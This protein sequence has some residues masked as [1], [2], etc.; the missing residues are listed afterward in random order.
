MTSPGEQVRAIFFSVL[1][2]TSMIAGATA[3]AGATDENPSSDTNLT[4]TGLN[5]TGSTEG[6][7][8]SEADSSNQDKHAETKKENSNETSQ[9]EETEPDDEVR[10]SANDTPE[11]TPE[12]TTEDTPA[13]SNT[14]TN[15]NTSTADFS[16]TSKKDDADVDPPASDKVTDNLEQR[17]KVILQG[18]TTVKAES[19]SIDDSTEE[20]STVTVQRGTIPNNKLVQVLIRASSEDAMESVVTDVQSHGSVV[21]S[22]TDQRIIAAEVPANRVEQII[23]SSA[24]ERVGIDERVSRNSATPPTGT[25]TRQVGNAGSSDSD[26]DSWGMEYIDADLVH[27]SGINGSGVS[28]AVLDGGIDQTAGLQ[29]KVVAEEDLA[30]NSPLD[31]DDPTDYSG[32]GSNVAGI[33]AASEST[34]K[35]PRSSNNTRQIKGVSPGVNLM[36]GKIGT[37]DDTLENRPVSTQSTDITDRQQVDIPVNIPNTIDGLGAGR[38]LRV[39]ATWSDPDDDISVEL[40]DGNGNTISQI[41]DGNGLNHSVQT[42]VD[43]E[44]KTRLEANGTSDFLLTSAP[45]NPDFDVAEIRVIGEN[46]SGTATV[47]LDI[48]KYA[49]GRSSQSTIAEGIY[50]ASGTGTAN[51]FVSPPPSPQQTADVISLSYSVGSSPI[52]PVTG[53]M[54]SAVDNDVV[55]VTSAGNDGPSTVANAKQKTNIISVGA[56]NRSGARAGFSQTG[57]SSSDIYKPDVIAP[58]TDIP[59]SGPT[60][61]IPQVSGQYNGTE[62]SGTSQAAPH[63][64]GVAALYIQMYERVHGESPTPQQVRSGIIAGTSDPTTPGNPLDREYSEEKG[65]GV[66]N[67]YNTYLTFSFNGTNSGE[68]DEVSV[69]VPEELPEDRITVPN[70][71][72]NI[73]GTFYRQDQDD[74]FDV[75]VDGTSAAEYGPIAVAES[76]ITASDVASFTIEGTNFGVADNDEEWALATH[77]PPI[78]QRIENER[79]EGYGF[80]PISLDPGES[81]AYVA[82]VDENTGSIYYDNLGAIRAISYYNSTQGDIDVTSQLPSDGVTVSSD[83]NTTERNTEQVVTSRPTDSGKVLFEADETPGTV[84][85]SHTSNYPLIPLP[86]E[87]EVNVIDSSAGNASSPG[88]IGFE[89]EIENGNLPYTYSGYNP[90]NASNFAVEVGQR[91]ASN[92][93]VTEQRQD[94]YNIRANAPVQQATGSFNLSVAFTDS[95]HGVSHTAKVTEPDVIGYSGQGSSG[96]TSVSLIL[97]VSGSMGSGPNSDLRQSKDASS[98]FLQQTKSGDTVAVVAYGSSAVNGTETTIVGGNRSQINQTIYN[99]DDLGAGGLT[100]ISGGLTLGRQNL[101]VAPDGTTKAAVLLSDGNRNTGQ[102]ES[103]ITNTIMPTYDANG[104][105]IYTIAFGGGADK[106]L[107]KDIAN[108]TDDSGNVSASPDKR[109]YADPDQDA[110]RQIY[111][112]IKDV[113]ATTSTVQSTSGSVAPGSVSQNSVSIDD[114]ISSASIDININDSGGSSGASS[115]TVAADQVQ[116]GSVE[117]RLYDPSNQLVKQNQSTATGTNRSDVEYSSIGDTTTY[118]LTDPQPG[119]WSYEIVNNQQSGNISYDAGVSGDTSTTLSVAT[120][121]QQYTNGS[122]ARLTATVL[123][124]SGVV[125]GASVVANV[126]TPD[127]SVQT[128]PL[129]ENNAGK[130][131]GTLNLE[132]SGAYSAEIAAS[133]GQITRTKDT[134]WSVIDKSSVI[135]ITQQTANLTTAVGGTAV[136]SLNATLPTQASTTASTSASESGQTTEAGT[137]DGQSDFE[138][139]ARE[140]ATLSRDEIRSAN[141]SE[142]VRQAALT[143]KDAQNNSESASVI[144]AQAT[145]SATSVQ[146]KTVFASASDLQ[147]PANE[148]IS[149]NRVSITPQSYRATEGT[150]RNVTVEV[151]VPGKAPEGSYNGTVTFAVDGILVEQQ[152][153][154]NVTRATTDVYVSRIKQT[155]VEWES[156]SSNGKAV[157]EDQIGDHL[158]NIYFSSESNAGTSSSISNV[159]SNPAVRTNRGEYYE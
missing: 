110:I 65:M 107:M 48:Q 148:L 140:L 126:T 123:G 129:T 62:M 147:G 44:T 22:F 42:T 72:A 46:V 130:Y 49:A 63:V 78:G 111:Q 19:Q 33:I 112:D 69:R 32:H 135:Q 40:I 149:A 83:I 134:S 132:N 153:E 117:T 51:P 17:L 89:V 122:T 21:S 124:S 118:R 141:V 96:A 119:D 75:A 138:S 56:S 144:E 88:Q 131:V 142:P 84:E 5:E 61:R 145:T 114:S 52:N 29:G 15:Q 31:G 77:Y 121:S 87:A 57:D 13:E 35:I 154:V 82:P 85:L 12:N 93:T 159:T 25:I 24:V 4:E 102:S 158:T 139:Q 47:N 116:S 28:V 115:A 125:S 18:G 97:D 106:K 43:E 143:I 155:T 36:N 2:I 150:S 100:N 73:T 128:I 105:N 39:D 146:G 60:T 95:K 152:I 92:L 26:L 66:V 91:P 34:V 27:Q 58:G 45:N 38:L 55:F 94:K 79:I 86:S 30:P 1:M 6:S 81:A 11:D 53:A 157:Y 76:N 80:R 68:E 103:E 64:S 99:V 71:D 10:G 16:G 127:G 67:A 3:V 59:S 9:T 74:E 109:F 8:P 54:D 156:A 14:G 20:T 113:I 137:D 120:D 41:P 98:I 108:V 50:W 104:Y 136:G 37:Y 23:Q 70:N 90:P 151:N 7:G 101:D 133:N